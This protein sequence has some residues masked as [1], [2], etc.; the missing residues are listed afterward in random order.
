MSELIRNNDGEAFSLMLRLVF[1]AGEA[2]NKQVSF[3]G[4][5]GAFEPWPPPQP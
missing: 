1:T 2:W 4:F 5:R 3:Q